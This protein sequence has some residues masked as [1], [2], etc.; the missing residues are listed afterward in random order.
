MPILGWMVLFTGWSLLALAIGNAS[1]SPGQGGRLSRLAYRLRWFPLVAAATLALLFVLAFSPAPRTRLVVDVSAN[2][3]RSFT[4]PRRV[5]HAIS[6]LERRG[7]AGDMDLVKIETVEPTAP[8]VVLLKLIPCDDCGENTIAVDGNSAKPCTE[9]WDNSRC[10]NLSAE[11][12]RDAE[13][14]MVKVDLEGILAA[15]GKLTPGR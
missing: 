14:L 4:S 15:N 7:L 3:T 13:E 5:H 6:A 10:F 12:P 9:D 1:R 11:Y 2:S 8:L